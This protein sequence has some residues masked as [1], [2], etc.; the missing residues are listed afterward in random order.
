MKYLLR[1]AIL[2]MIL[3]SCTTGWQGEEREFRDDMRVFVQRISDHAHDT[4]ADFIVIPQN[5]HAILTG[6]GSADG[7]P[8][9]DYIAAIDG[10]GREDLFYGYDADDEPT[11]AEDNEAMLAFMDLAEEQGVE[12]LATDYC[13]TASYMDDSYTR[14]ASHG[15]ISF[16][17]DSRDLDTIPDYPPE[18]YEVHPGDVT[19]LADAKNFLYLLDPS[20]YTTKAGYLGA[21]DG[22]DYDLVIMDLF[23]EDGDGNV[24]ALNSDDLAPLKTKANGGSRLLICY[25]SIGEAEDYRFYW[26][27][28]WDRDPPEWIAA[29]NPLW[30]GNYKVEYW[31]T[32]WQAI[33][34]G[35]DSAYLDKILD[36]GFDGVYLDIIDA[37]E[38]FEDALGL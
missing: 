20:A 36:A 21:I 7:T 3:S 31:D 19:T 11:P 27:D 38:F 18:P 37:Y 2:A 15:F 32:D 5:G 1:F 34:F 24:A 13:S 30:R 28:D 8:A 25:M 4:D 16:A 22:T 14:N 26:Q 9:A 12:V 35:S 10:V 17:A 6:N 29:E 33:I 23:F